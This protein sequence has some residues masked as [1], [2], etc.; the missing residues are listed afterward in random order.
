MAR[1]LRVAFYGAGQVSTNAS[2]IL[3]R[4][5]DIAVLGPF[6]RSER[7]RGAARQAPTSS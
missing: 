6:G 7:D 4:R 5:S 2:A 1:P 3:R